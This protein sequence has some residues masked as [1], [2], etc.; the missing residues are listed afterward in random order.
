[1]RRRK[2]CRNNKCGDYFIPCAQVPHQSYCSKPECQRV[3]KREW[4]RRKLANDADY[5][6]NRK[7]AQ[8]R[9][10]KKNSGYWRE[11]R[12]RHQESAAR[13]RRDQGP[14]NLR[15]KLVS[16]CNRIAK[17]DECLAKNIVLTGRY[18]LVPIR[19]D[20]IAKTDESIIEMIAIP[21]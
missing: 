18:R 14:R 16:L 9:W 6:E 15:R 20:T 12:S 10:A 17:T 5:R 21:A 3:R 8:R 19:G 2:R 13:N 1:M 7:D 4:N 11:Y